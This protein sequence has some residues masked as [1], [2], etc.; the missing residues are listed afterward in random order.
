MADVL[1]VV[2]EQLRARKA[3][4][5]DEIVTLGGQLADLERAISAISGSAVPVA[6]DE[7]AF[8]AFAA[9]LAPKSN[10]DEPAPEPEPPVVDAVRTTGPRPWSDE[11]KN[12][13]RRLYA[14]GLS[15][16]EIAETLGRTPAACSQRRMMLDIP[17]RRP[18]HRSKVEAQPKALR[19]FTET[20][21]LMPAQVAA[22]PAEHAAVTEKRS[23][24]PHSVVEAHE[25]PRILVSGI[26]SRKLG[27]KVTK[28]PW[29]DMPVF[30]V[31]LEERATCPESCHHWLT[32]YG[33]AM[34]HAR[35]HKHG[36]F[37]EN[38][39]EDEL[40]QLQT[41]RMSGFVVRLHQL[42]DF[43]SVDYV[44]RW[45]RWLKSFDG[46]HV[47]GYTAWPR[48]TPI[49]AAVAGLTAKHWERFAIR[50]SSAEAKPQGAT[51][52]WRQPEAAVVAEGIVC[53]AQTGRTDCCG[54]CGLCWHPNAKA[55]TI[56]FVAHGPK[57]LPSAQEAAK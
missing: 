17:S 29:R 13:L 38:M 47:F 43:Y 30:S 40:A 52:I 4:L 12:E 51:T 41:T 55:K 14:A 6:E 10:E 26:N 53:P 45:E 56:A 48:S 19:R 37:F 21:P 8:Q 57:T 35:R 16:R 20:K 32:C 2:V 50:F 31:T 36:R 44:K 34:P 24:F 15:M 46:L 5:L 7:A 54:T 11:D 49:G 18:Y 22:L 27:S 23:F 28:G 42:G 39:L 3:A 1:T 9:A 25:S 33:N